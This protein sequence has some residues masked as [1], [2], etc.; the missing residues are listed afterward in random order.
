MSITFPL[1]RGTYTGKPGWT[2]DQGVDIAAPGHTPLLAVASGTIVRH[3]IGG[4]G[5]W[6]PVLKLDQPIGGYRYVYYGHAGPG[7]AVPVG[8]HVNAGQ[9]I[10]EVGAGKVGISNGPH[11]E[12]GFSDGAGTPAGPKG[13]A[14]AH[15][16]YAWLS[17]GKVEKKDSV[18]GISLPGLS[19]A[20]DPNALS[21]DPS[22]AADQTAK[23]IV[24]DLLGAANWKYVAL[25]IV[26]VGGGFLLT[27]RGALELFGKHKEPAPA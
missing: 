12:I 16:I 21:L 15:A 2:I 14:Q 7:N 8:T 25:V 4:F 24:H 17:G 20:N 3:G 6:A 26:L 1:P 5:D 9:V 18:L 23:F 22:T 27:G 13:G 10:G 11:L 19:G